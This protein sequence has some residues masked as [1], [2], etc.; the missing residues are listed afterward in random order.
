MGVKIKKHS[1][2]FRLNEMKKVFKSG[3]R[4][5]ITEG[6]I[7]KQNN[8]IVEDVTDENN[9]IIFLGVSFNMRDAMRMIN[10]ECARREREQISK[11]D[12]K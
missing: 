10:R 3:R 6:V 2:K 5:V 1:D 4:F 7:N 12:Y 8:F 11:L 9:C